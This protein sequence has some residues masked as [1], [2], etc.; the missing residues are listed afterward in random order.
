MSL[1]L[2][3]KLKLDCQ[4]ILEPE[5]KNTTAAI[6]LASCLTKVN[7]DYLLILPSDHLIPDKNRFNNMIE[8]TR[9]NNK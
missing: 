5:P 8:K 4:I 6:Y 3:N 9:N 7:E 2:L 1:N